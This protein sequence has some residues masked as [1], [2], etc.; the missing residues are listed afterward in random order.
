MFRWFVRVE[1]FIK[2]SSLFMQTDVNSH[3]EQTGTNPDPLFHRLHLPG[4]RISYPH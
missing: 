3:I 2:K 1:K 4:K